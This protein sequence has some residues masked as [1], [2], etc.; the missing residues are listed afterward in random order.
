MKKKQNKKIPAFPNPDC[1]GAT[2]VGGPQFIL[3]GPA[4]AVWPAQSIGAPLVVGTE[5]NPNPPLP[6][7]TTGVLMPP[8]VPPQLIDVGT[9]LL[10]LLLM[11]HVDW[12]AVVPVVLP[13]PPLV[14]S[15]NTLHKS[16][17]AAYLSFD[18]LGG[19][20][21]AKAGAV[22]DWGNAAKPPLETVHDGPVIP[23]GW[24]GAG[25]NKIASNSSLL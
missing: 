18:W 17:K 3:V 13:L 19:W 22:D 10:E 6:L 11:F 9:V 5:A 21:F 4:V 25:N 15:L 2:P 16:A 14:L 8:P 12:L 7:V 23:N 20:V 1:G 24:S